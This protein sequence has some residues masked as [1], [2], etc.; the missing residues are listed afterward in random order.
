MMTEGLGIHIQNLHKSFK[1]REVIHDL[2]LDIAAGSFVSLVGPSGCGKST[3]LRLIAGLENPTNGEV[4]LSPPGKNISGFVFQEANLLPWRNVFENVALPFELRPEFQSLPEKDKKLRVLAAL[5]KVQLE[6]SENLFPHELSGG[7]KMR[8]SLARAVV[9][10]PRL[11]LMDEPFA[12]LDE[13][14]RFEMQNQLLDLWKKEKMTIVFV[15]HSLFEAVYLSER[16]IML[17]GPDARIV[18]DE[19]VDLPFER[20]EDLRTSEKLNQLVRGVSARLRA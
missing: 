20:T 18:I 3:L 2:S 14:T 16:I 17:K 7:M 11:L 8:V 4:S 10:T 1:K 6:G 15:T 5:K 12:A 13:N 9:H 19:K